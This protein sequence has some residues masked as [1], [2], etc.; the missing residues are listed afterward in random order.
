MNDT[1]LRFA[2]LQM[3][4]DL[5][6]SA[7]PERKIMDCADRLLRFAKTGERVEEKPS[8]LDIVRAS[9]GG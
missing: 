9:Q 8:V 1:D 5:L 4:V 6:G 7:Y 2:C 3:A